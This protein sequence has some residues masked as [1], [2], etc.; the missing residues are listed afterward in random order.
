MKTSTNYLKK[1]LLAAIIAALTSV[2]NCNSNTFEI[3]DNTKKLDSSYDKEI[4]SVSVVDVS[5]EDTAPLI[6]K[7]NDSILIKVKF[8]NIVNVEK[9]NGTPAITLADGITA[10]YTSGNGTDVLIFEYIVQPG[11]NFSNIDYTAENALIL[12]GGSIT[13]LQNNDVDL[14]LPK[15]GTSSLAP[16]LVTIDGIIPE[17]NIV[18]II[19]NNVNDTSLAKT[20]D[21][22]AVHITASESLSAA[23]T[24][25]ISGNTAVVS[26]TGPYTAEFTMTESEAEG[27][28]F[29]TIDFADIVG[30]KGIQVTTVLDSSSVNFDKTPPVFNS[31][32]GANEA[33]DNL[34]ELPERNSTNEIVVLSASG[35][36]HP[37]NMALYTSI[38]NDNPFITCDASQIYNNSIIPAINT[39]S[40]VDGT[41]IVCVKLEDAAGNITYGKSSQ[42]IKDTASITITESGTTDISE[43]GITDSYD[44]VLTSEPSADVLI[45]ILAN[46]QLTAN[47]SAS[48]QL[49]FTPFNW[50]LP[51]TVSVS[52]V[53]DNIVETTLHIGTITHILNASSASEY[54]GKSI[55]PVMANITDNDNMAFV[56][57]VSSPAADGSYKAADILPVYIIF[58]QIL[59]VDTTFGN[60]SLTLDTGTIFY[61]SGT[62]TDTLEFNYIVGASD[63]SNDLSYINTTALILNGGSIKDIYGNDAN[64]TLI[65][66]GS[67]GSLSFNKNLVIDTSS[68][69]VNWVTSSTADGSYD[70]GSA[71]SIEI[72]FSES[73]FV[74]GGTPAL[75]L[76]TGGIDAIANY[77]SGSGTNTL[78]FNYT[79]EPEHQSSDL[80]YVANNALALSG[81]FIKDIAGNDANL[82][83]PNPGELNSLSY[84]KNIIIDGA[85]P[86]I[87]NV[88]S[89]TADASYKE[90]DLILVNIVFSEIVDID[91]TGGTPSLALNSGGAALYSSGTG[92][93]VLTFYYT[94]TAGENT[95]D[96]D[97]TN[98]N[99]LLLN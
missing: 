63:I 31:L 68:P 77:S 33:A 57:N 59:N 19:S 58:N 83:L 73:V 56:L 14:T 21:R 24:V 69:S 29:F 9:T 15:P 17:L 40:D 20:G 98:S 6:Y 93:A 34:L 3:F 91:V 62:G 88:T 81:A 52:A 95:S 67:A 30:N 61:T 46:S 54:I 78:F 90:T 44:V 79:V 4:L 47:E 49:T 89:S 94:I 50:S 85:I 76:E 84:N 35:N 48:F 26:G 23:P 18:S 1:I 38:I 80:D 55:N 92:T 45:D 32:A 5:L 22:I 64:L 86:V 51:Q 82:T 87:T 41:Y 74:T 42:I 37:I 75:T 60:P 16:L 28:V 13:N 12:N 10:V 36:D 65:N 72:V 71:V 8:D 66:P 96:L 99:A 25:T 43:D 97:Y 7:L 11:D 2:Y 27:M 70:S 53:N 39:I